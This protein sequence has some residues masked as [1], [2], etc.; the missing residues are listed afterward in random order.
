[1]METNQK[2]IKTKKHSRTIIFSTVI[3]VLYLLGRFMP[4][5]DCECT[6]E[7]FSHEI[8][9]PNGFIMTKCYKKMISERGLNKTPEQ[10]A[11]IEVME[12]YSKLCPDEAVPKI[13]W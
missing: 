9:L 10:V 2:P 1:M 6:K 4:I 13:V 7:V 5:S 3:I 11:P 8:P 12:Y